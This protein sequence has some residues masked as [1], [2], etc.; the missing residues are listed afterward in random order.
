MFQQGRTAELKQTLYATLM[1]RLAKETGLRE[2]DLIVT[3]TANQKED[4]SFGKGRAQF[5][6]GD[7]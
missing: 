4:W 3:C 5:L 1:E 2:G 6:V 7:L